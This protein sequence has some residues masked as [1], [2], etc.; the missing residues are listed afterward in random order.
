MIEQ[1]GDK[2]E[3]ILPQ[4]I[5]ARFWNIAG[6]IVKDQLANWITTSNWKKVPN[7][8]NDVLWAK[9][10]EKFVFR[11]GLIERLDILLR[12]SLEDV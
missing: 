4:G 8:T 10:K 3:P 2:G 11:K 12:A 5:A 1:L 6:A 7:A 9:L